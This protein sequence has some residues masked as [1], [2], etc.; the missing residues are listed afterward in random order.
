MIY[1]VRKYFS[2][3]AAHWR[4]LSEVIIVFL[5]SMVPLSISA[6][7]ALSRDGRGLDTAFY[8][9]FGHGQAYL[10][11]YALF[12]TVFWL[13]FV[14]G[15]RP[16][17]NARIFLGVI[18]TFMMFPIFGFSAVDPTFSTI[19]NPESVRYSF[20]FYFTLLVINYLLIFYLHVDPPE[21]AGIFKREADDMGR[22]YRD[23]LK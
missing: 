15:D 3:P 5:F 6:F 21:P 19:I 9:L 17:H 23:E 14:K 7:K 12:G 13:A 16:R 10:L 20:Y 11:G 4:A 8:D 22:R 1:W 2:D 18:A